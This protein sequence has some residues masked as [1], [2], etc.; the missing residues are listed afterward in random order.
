MHLI[1]AGTDNAP[2]REEGNV[3]RVLELIGKTILRK[4]LT[5]RSTACP[6][7]QTPLGSWL[8]CFSRQNLSSDTKGKRDVLKIIL[9]CSEGADLKMM[10]G[11]G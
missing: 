4:L 2:K 5:E 6:G 1:F 8:D 9:D 3:K 7:A 10:D 11:V